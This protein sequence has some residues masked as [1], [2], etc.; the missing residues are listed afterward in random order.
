MVITEIMLQ[1]SGFLSS[2]MRRTG[3][4][5]RQGDTDTREAPRGGEGD[6][7]LRRGARAG[8]DSP[9]RDAPR[10]YRVRRHFL[11]GPFLVSTTP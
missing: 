7:S 6:D 2:N 11:R 1:N 4:A 5:T 8:A 3:A 9:L 10:H